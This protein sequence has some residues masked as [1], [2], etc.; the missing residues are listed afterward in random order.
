[1]RSAVISGVGMTRFGKH[2]DRSLKDLGADATQAALADAGVEVG[3]IRAIFF[4]NCVAGLITGQEMIRGETVAFPMGFGSIPIHNLENA[5]G[6]GGNALHLAWLSVASGLCDTALALGVEKLHHPDVSRTF[7]AYGTGTDIEA[8]F[9][10]AEGAGETR[11]PLVDRQAQLAKELME[12]RGVSLD[13]LARI[14]A[15][16]LTSAALN[17]NAHRQFGGTVESVLSARMSV[18]PITVLMSS[19]VSDGAAAAVVTA[20]DPGPRDVRILASRLAS[21]PPLDQ[22]DGPPAARAA[23]LLAYE[24]AGL[25][26]ADVDVAEVHDASVA[27]EFLAWHDLGLCP[28]GDE[29]KWAQTGVTERDGRLPINATGGLVGR[30]HPLAAS[31]LA[32][33]HDLVRQ[34]RGE[35][36][37]LQLASQPRVALAQIGGGVIDW[38][39]SV[40]TV[41]ILTR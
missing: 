29:E 18:D 27:Y 8:P 37:D 21:R 1:M 15:R 17:P 24:D 20:R 31:G 19:P 4:G 22:P 36:G 3:D 33:T 6:T 12:E 30:G 5:C 11:T 13:S 39:T 26:P 40:G 38:M 16:S 28:P 34:L 41:H 35:A 14:A 25:G 9:A 7:S 2:L 23:S 10:T 32:Q